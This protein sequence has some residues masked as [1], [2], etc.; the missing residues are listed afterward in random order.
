[1]TTAGGDASYGDD[2]I[3]MRLAIDIPDGTAA[4]LQEIT[5]E[6]ERLRVAMEATVRAE[7]DMGRF[8]SQMTEA[9]GQAAQ[10]QANLTQQ[11]QAYLSLSSRVSSTAPS[12]GVP[13]GGAVN[14]FGGA[15]SGMGTGG[16][17]VPPGE[18]PPNSSDVS[19]QINQMP[20]QNPREY[21]N[22]QQARGGVTDQ[23]TV[24]IT[25]SSINQMANKIADREKANAEQHQKTDANPPMG[26][27]D[28]SGS[29]MHERVQRATSL[30][31]QVMNEMGPRGSIYGMGQL[32]VRGMQWAAK[33]MSKQVPSRGSSPT[34]TSDDQGGLGGAPGG[35]STP[36][37]PTD[38]PQ[39]E[40]APA[41]DS[42]GGGIIKTLIGALG[43]IGKVA[44][45]ALA[46][47]AT[48]EKGGAMVQGARNV[49]SVR[50]GAAGEGF[51]VEAKA[52]M[53]S[54]NPFLSQ[55]QARQ[56]YQAVM[57]EGYADASGSGAD[58]VIDF[59]KHNLTNMNI[60]VADSARMLRSTIVGNVKGDPE[61]VSGAVSLLTQEMD[62]IRTLSRQ[63]VMSQPDF[64]NKTLNMQQALMDQGASPEAAAKSAMIATQQG[65]GDQ[66]LKGAY[67]D[68]GAGLGGTM[69]GE[70]M[71]RSYGGADIP[72]GLML[73]GT[74]EYLTETGQMESARMNV[75]KHYA[76][77]AYQAKED[78]T[79]LGR[80]NAISTFQ[81]LI[82]GVPGAGEIASKRGSVAA[83]YADLI[84]D[85][86]LGQAEA[87]VG[88]QPSLP[89]S[90]GQG[91]LWGPGSSMPELGGPPTPSLGPGAGTSGSNGSVSVGSRAP[92]SGG[93]GGGGASS[94]TITLSP[95]A[96]KLLNVMGPST[97]RL[98]PSEQ[99]AKK[100]IAGAHMNN[101]GVGE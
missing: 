66:V 68:I 96:A 74:T 84:K 4:G 34:S 33:R 72:G 61:S 88:E 32:A 15:S 36:P 83:L 17:Y 70:A 41:S 82:R 95:E 19:Y 12:M 85:Q 30:A 21:L 80:S 6:V 39:D 99:G 97:V 86:S 93:G 43:P 24:G 35:G 31:G 57:S 100:G 94:V 38:P 87:A 77:Q 18:R 69:M 25:P 89:S 91:P 27:D 90:G 1:M 26:S 45:S 76:Q 101:Q 28:G 16:M 56:I 23:D 42:G 59:M 46:I 44:A 2:Y 79:K 10:A 37:P 75:M 20:R 62:N 55:D 9:S 92:A 3:A 48:I 5:S 64:R 13:T 98:S 22:M 81:M 52:R 53:L 50:G 63:G 49:A 58:N 65:S 47:Y 14:P 51:E 11:L 40:N 54:M 60:S 78:G 7:A 67:S 71:L 8:L 73:Q 29:T